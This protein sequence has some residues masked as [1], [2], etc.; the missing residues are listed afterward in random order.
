MT[1]SI[2]VNSKI[3]ADDE[4]SADE[5]LSVGGGGGGGGGGVNVSQDLLSF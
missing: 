5:R 2:N 1:F 4:M 3:S